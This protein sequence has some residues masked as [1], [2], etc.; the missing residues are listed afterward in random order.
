MKMISVLWRH[1]FEKVLE[2]FIAS[3]V[4]VSPKLFDNLQE[5]MKSQPRSQRPTS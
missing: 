5:H 1:V 2:E 3:S 4:R